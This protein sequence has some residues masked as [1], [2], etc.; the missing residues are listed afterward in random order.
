MISLC[1]ILL[2]AIA[3][4]NGKVFEGSCPESK[5]EYHISNLIRTYSE[6][7][8]FIHFPLAPVLLM[9]G[10]PSKNHFFRNMFGQSPDCWNIIF[11]IPNKTSSWINL[12]FEQKMNSEYP[13]GQPCMDVTQQIYSIVN[14]SDVSLETN[15]G[16]RY[17]DRLFTVCPSDLNWDVEIQ[18]MEVFTESFESMNSERYLVVWACQDLPD[19]THDLGMIVAYRDSPETLHLP[20]TSKVI[21]KRTSIVNKSLDLVRSLPFATT[22]EREDFQEILGDHNGNCDFCEQY[23]CIM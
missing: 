4:I 14:G 20:Q 15:D 19:G 6:F 16:K 7:K 3:L 23:K 5:S 22:L 17:P 2:S 10:P 12:Y 18:A 13:E 21:E 11:R 8:L 1:V 9:P